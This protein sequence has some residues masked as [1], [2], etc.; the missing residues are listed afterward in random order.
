[1]PVEPVTPARTRNRDDNAAHRILNLLFMLNI[2]RTPLSTEQIIDADELGYTSS[3]RDSS[4]KKFRRDREKLAEHGIV[5]REIREDGARE[6][7]SSR[8]AIDRKATQA[9]L[10][11]ILQ[12]DAEAL[13]D[14]ID[15]HLER[16]DIPYRAA[17]ER[18]RRKVSQGAGV[19][20]RAAEI[21]SDR[22]GQGAANPALKVIWTAFS[23]R[24]KLPLVYRDAKGRESR[25][26]V[27]IFGIFTLEGN[28]YFVGDDGTGSC[29]TFRADRVTRTLLPRG[30]YRIPPDFDV[31]D[32]LFLPFDFAPGDGVVATFRFDRLATDE[33]I[34]MVTRGR[35]A[36]ERSGEETR[37]RVQARSLTAAAA[38]ALSHQTP[39]R[40]VPEGPR[41]LIDAWDELIS[42]AVTKHE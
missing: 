41:E 35:G 39:L 36:L 12:E 14:A 16:S 15:E 32:Y 29:K 13:I 34:R 21:P 38:W 25:R 31:C 27:S 1:M 33:E 42:Q 19:L 3:N 18:I 40:I 9:D 7:E 8:W 22:G 26:T 23:L 5:I 24:Q 28:C 11:L 6:T 10:G 17:L 4:L 30:T 37:W 20:P 2:S